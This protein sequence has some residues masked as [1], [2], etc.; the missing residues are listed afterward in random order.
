MYAMACI[1]P[2]RRSL[3]FL[4]TNR[5]AWLRGAIRQNKDNFHPN[6]CRS[7]THNINN[8]DHYIYGI[9]RASKTGVVL[10]RQ[11]STTV[12]PRKEGSE[13]YVYVMRKMYYAEIER[14]SPRSFDHLHTIASDPIVVPAATENF[15][16]VVAP[17]VFF[18][19]RRYFSPQ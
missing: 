17:N 2:S 1:L 14:T 11:P 19:R 6:E 9:C 4:K 13:S 8:I 12:V 3:I 7:K 15:P 16:L 5:S 10:P 18:P